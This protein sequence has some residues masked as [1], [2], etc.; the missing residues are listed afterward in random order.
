MCAEIA[1]LFR[2]PRDV[3]GRKSVQQP[4]I[5][6]S[7]RQMLIFCSTNFLLVTV[8]YFTIKSQNKFNLCFSLSSDKGVYGQVLADGCSSGNKKCYRSSTQVEAEFFTSTVSQISKGFI[9]IIFYFSLMQ[10]SSL[11]KEAY[12]DSY[13]SLCFCRGLLKM[14]FLMPPG[15]SVVQNNAW[16]N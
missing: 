6:L 15:F 9:Y 1:P 13:Q 11:Q 10:S 16:R 7:S 14:R 4:I 3:H 5:A 8:F 2:Q 12:S